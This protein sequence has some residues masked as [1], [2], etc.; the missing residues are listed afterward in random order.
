LTTTCST[1]SKKEEAQV[2]YYEMYIE[3]DSIP[4]EYQKVK[5]VD[6]NGFRKQFTYNYFVTTGVMV[7]ESKNYYKILG[8][9]LFSIRKNDGNGVLY[10]ST[11]HIDSCIT[12]GT[13][14][15]IM[16]QVLA[17]TNC[18]QGKKSII[19]NNNEFK[20]A[21]EFYKTYGKGLDNVMC[22]VYYDTSLIPIKEE[23]ISGGYTPIDSIRRTN[24][25][26]FESISRLK[27]VKYK[28]YTFYIRDSL[29]TQQ[30]YFNV[31]TILS[32]Y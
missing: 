6:S 28:K 26:P 12:Y 9:D 17:E 11:K 22:R 4:L 3:A 20:T 30:K 2:Y 7:F 8:G 18:F 16:D 21:Y 29:K 1:T 23:W 14:N 5:I 10:L 25:V 13:G 31:K 24:C 27:C 19:V 32:C 15:E